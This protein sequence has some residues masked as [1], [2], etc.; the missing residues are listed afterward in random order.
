MEIS[1][2]LAP[3]ALTVL[4]FALTLLHIVRSIPFNDTGE[5]MLY[6][7]LGGAGLTAGLYFALG[8]TSQNIYL[9]VAPYM[10]AA[11]WFPLSIAVCVY[12]ANLLLSAR[13]LS[14]Y[15]GAVFAGWLLALGGIVFLLHRRDLLMS[16]L[17]LM[18]VRGHF[19]PVF[20]ALPV[21]SLW[22]ALA[23]THVA[24]SL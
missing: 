18:T 2:P 13:P 20:V 1:L 21:V 19:T 16:V 12:L 4:A 22:T 10:V 17:H 8:Y 15:T 23:L 7:S 11:L 9:S 14:F 6:I 3:E 24:L 5:E